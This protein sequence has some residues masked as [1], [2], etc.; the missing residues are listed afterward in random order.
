VGAHQGA[1]ARGIIGIGLQGLQDA[2]D[3]LVREAFGSQLFMDGRPGVSLLV[4]DARAQLR[5]GFIIQQPTTRRFLN[6]GWDQPLSDPALL[7]VGAELSR[8]TIPEPHIPLRHG[9]GAVS[10]VLL[11]THDPSTGN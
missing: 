3:D 4:Q 1:S 2:L 9:E 5:A 6:D 10:P 11:D 8:R 7:Q